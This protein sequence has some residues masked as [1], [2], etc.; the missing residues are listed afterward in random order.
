MLSDSG[1]PGVIYGRVQDVIRFSN[2]GTATVDG[3]GNRFEYT[4]PS[5]IAVSH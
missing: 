4:L 3:N 1:Y 5:C 2:M